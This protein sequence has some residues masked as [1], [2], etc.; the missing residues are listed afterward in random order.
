MANSLRHVVCLYGCYHF[1]IG[2]R[3]WKTSK[4]IRAVRRSD[5]KKGK[6]INTFSSSDSDFEPPPF[7]KRSK[8][9]DVT[10]EDRLKKLEADMQ[11]A[12]SE[13]QEKSKE[14]SELLKKSKKQ[15]DD[16]RQCFECVICKCSAKHPAVVS[17]C[18]SI[19]LGCE[20]CITRWLTD[21]Q[22][23]PHCRRNIKMDECMKL[24]FIR[25]LKEALSES[26]Q[27]ANDSSSSSSEIVQVD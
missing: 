9:S 5:F 7:L 6:S 22:Q 12:N 3:F 24:P 14:K 16:L 18:C 23:C 1:C 20:T 21:N 4:R 26:S 19:V 17:P 8:V 13:L 11:R 25:S 27:S 15:F 2:S 10:I